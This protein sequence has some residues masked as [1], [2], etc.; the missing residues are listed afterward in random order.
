MKRLKMVDT[1]TSSICHPKWYRSSA[2]AHGLLTQ[3]SNV[4][5]SEEEEEKEGFVVILPSLRARPQVPRRRCCDRGPCF[6]LFLVRASSQFF[7]AEI[8]VPVGTAVRYRCLDA[9]ALSPW[10]LAPYAVAQR[11]LVVL[12]VSQSSWD[13][14][15]SKSGEGRVSVALARVVVVIV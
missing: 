14:P 2:S 15:R 5:D 1:G 7:V 12:F 9:A 13:S 6:Y 4:H 3:N 11:R 8:T 10:E